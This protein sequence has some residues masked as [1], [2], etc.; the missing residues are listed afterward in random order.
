MINV[1]KFINKR[2]KLLNYDFTNSK[3]VLHILLCFDNNY[4]LS[5]GVDVISII[6]NNKHLEIHF[7]LFTHNIS[8]ENR[9][10]FALIS[11]DKIA[12]TE[13]IIN[14]QFQIDHKNT[15]QFPI[16][17]CVRLIAPIVLKNTAER[18]L[19]IDSD[20]LCLKHLDILLDIPL[21]NI[22]VAAVAD[23]PYMQESQC[24]KYGIVK[25]AY[26]NSGVMLININLWCQKD[27]TSKT[28]QILNSGEKFNYPD[29]DV[30]NIVVGNQRKILERKYNN[31][32]GLS[33]YGNEDSNVPED[34]VF[35]HYITKNKPWHQPYKTNLFDY[36]LAKS[37][38]KNDILPLYNSKK[39]S[40]IRAY[41]KLMFKEKKY[42]S[43]VI[44]YM[45]YL[46]T[47]FIK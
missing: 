8:E 23:A 44:Q 27:V 14:D 31:L 5:A 4:A 36:Y 21:D 13:Y 6:E 2:K 37:P 40:S 15:E 12:I 17:A 41:S 43:A 26:F 19:Y 30:L 11:A 18:L 10:K 3:Q 38:W 16:A 22:V 20:T 25:G 46:K 45:I 39:T 33:P 34:T 29:Q 32:L 9:Q 7:H 24:S 1:D 42:L 35:I 47:K 28:L